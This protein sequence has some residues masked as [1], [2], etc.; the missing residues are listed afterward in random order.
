MVSVLLYPVFVS[1]LV[2]GRRPS[3]GNILIMGQPVCDDDFTLINA[4]VACKQLGYIGAVSMTKES[5]YGRVSSNYA[6]DQGC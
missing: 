4:D 5:R 1:R 3:E 2:G 6:M